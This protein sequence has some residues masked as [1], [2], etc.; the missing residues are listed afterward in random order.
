[1]AEVSKYLMHR[2]TVDCNYYTSLNLTKVDSAYGML[3][4]RV[5]TL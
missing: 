2:V 3:V 1:M 4:T 5:K